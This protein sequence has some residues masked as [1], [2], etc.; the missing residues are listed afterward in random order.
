MNYY[1]ANTS[2]QLAKLMESLPPDVR[3]SAQIE[4]AL[5]ANPKTAIL[6]AMGR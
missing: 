6:R 5:G 2:K 1:D 4:I 3:K